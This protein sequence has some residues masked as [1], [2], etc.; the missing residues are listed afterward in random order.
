MRPSGRA[1]SELRPVS[2]EVGVTKHA[3]GSCL[4]K[5][6]DTHVLCTA[7][8]EARV[9]SFF[10]E[11]RSGMG[12]SGIWHVAPFH[13]LAD[14]ARGCRGQTGRANCGNSTTYWAVVACG[15]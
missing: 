7:S 11:C 5:V 14:A 2:I 1:L 12:D 13:R 10:E 9:P 6:G 15:Y 3:E 8:L 4:I